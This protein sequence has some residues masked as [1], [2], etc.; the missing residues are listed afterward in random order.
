[1]PINKQGKLC[2]TGRKP[3]KFKYTYEDIAR[4][5]GISLKTARLYACKKK[6]NPS[7][8]ASVIEFVLSRRQSS[9]RL[10]I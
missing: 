7:S 6:F 5:C 10:K 1:M 3:T 2:G 9:R 4:L 8:L